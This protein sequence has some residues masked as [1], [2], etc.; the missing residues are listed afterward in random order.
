MGCRRP[1]GWSL[2]LCPGWK[3]VGSEETRDGENV[4][5]CFPPS[6]S[7]AAPGSL[8]DTL[9]GGFTSLPVSQ[10]SRMKVLLPD[11]LLFSCVK[12]PA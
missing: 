7:L 12:L 11:F 10:T 2:G 1:R 9:S 5:A 6:L 3:A 8:S 4:P